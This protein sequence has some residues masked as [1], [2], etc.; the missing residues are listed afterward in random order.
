MIDILKPG[1]IMVIS[2]GSARNPDH[3]EASAPDCKF[4]ALKVEP[5]LRVLEAGGMYVHEL[6]YEKKYYAAM[7]GKEWSDKNPKNGLGEVGLIAF[8][9]PSYIVGPRNIDPIL[10]E[11]QIDGKMDYADFNLPMQGRLE[12]YAYMDF[13]RAYFRH[14]PVVRP[15]VV[16][17][18]IWASWQRPFYE[19][20]I[21]ATHIGIDIS[22]KA[23]VPDILG[24]SH[25]P[26][27]FEKL[28]TKLNGKLIDL[29]FIDAAHDYE[30]VRR[31]Y[32]IYA[33]LTKGIVALHDI[34][35]SDGPKRL[36]GELADRATDGQYFITLDEHNKPRTGIGIIANA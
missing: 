22:D 9:L 5:V 23:S 33:P 17:V 3:E 4:H 10:P 31:D 18:G 34:A 21:N 25:A 19:H 11:D 32:E 24:D 28:K 13:I 27:T 29:L 16:E 35:G 30:S 8:K 2:W 20:F 26:E 14:H 7:Y 6:M 36:W 1:G 12:W 15:I